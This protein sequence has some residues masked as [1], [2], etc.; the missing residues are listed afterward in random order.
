MGLTL[1]NADKQT[2][3]T[4][5][6]NRSITLSGSAVLNQPN[7]RNSGNSRLVNR[8]GKGASQD[9][10]VTNNISGLNEAQLSELLDRQSESLGKAIAALPNQPAPAVIIPSTGGTAP[11]GATDTFADA[12]D[13]RLADNVTEGSPSAQKKIPA[14]LWWIAGGFGILLVLVIIRYTRKKSA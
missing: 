8:L 4:N 13:N 9:N 10:S 11:A 7:T 14:A 6:V 2:T 12:L 5:N 3:L 1:G